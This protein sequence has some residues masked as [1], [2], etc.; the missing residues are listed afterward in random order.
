[1]GNPHGVI[2]SRRVRSSEKNRLERFAHR[3]KPRAS[4]SA[5]HVSEIHKTRSDI[6]LPP[7]SG[8][9]QDEQTLQTATERGEQHLSTRNKRVCASGAGPRARAPL[10]E[11]GPSP[12]PLGGNWLLLNGLSKA[13]RVPVG[14]SLGGESGLIAY[15]LGF[16]S[17]NRAR[18]NCVDRAH[19]RCPLL[20]L[21]G[22]A[23]S[24]RTVAMIGQ[25]IRRVR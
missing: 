4:K 6:P 5:V 7:R 10:R 22:R 13:E 12:K 19:V 1:M 23:R 24:H 25:T 20:A 2:L 14:A 15:E 21:A 17:L 9:W 8:S 16:G 11:V 3:L 18:T